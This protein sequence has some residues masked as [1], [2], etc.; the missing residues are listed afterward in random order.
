MRACGGCGKM[1]EGYKEVRDLNGQLH[2]CDRDIWLDRLWDY[3]EANP[4]D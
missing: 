3:Q 4:E 1:V 2:E